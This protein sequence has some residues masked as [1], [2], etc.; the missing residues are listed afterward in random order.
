MQKDTA[1]LKGLSMA[2]EQIRVHFKHLFADGT[3]MSC[4]HL[5]ELHGGWKPPER[6]PGKTFPL[7]GGGASPRGNGA[8]GSRS[9][10]ITTQDVF[11]FNSYFCSFFQWDDTYRGGAKSLLILTLS[12]GSAALISPCLHRVFLWQLPGEFSC[13]L[14]EV[15]WKQVNMLE[16]KWCR[17]RLMWPSERGLEKSRII[18]RKLPP[19][20]GLKLPRSKLFA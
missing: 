13:Y 3:H 17:R 20:R 1:L 16:M 15:N 19:R 7:L 4:C 12:S 5:A 9:I 6:T 2:S 14:G 11:R 8:I 10:T 18:C